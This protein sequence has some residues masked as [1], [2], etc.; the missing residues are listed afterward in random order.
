MIDLA[1]LPLEKLD[2]LIENHRAKKATDAPLYIQALAERARRKGNG[3]D[4]TTSLKA[5][6]KAAREQRFLGYKELADESGADWNKVYLSIGKHLDELAEYAHRKGWP[7]ISA[8]VVN[9]EN[10]ET[11]KLEPKSLKGF[12]TIARA[13]RHPV[14]DEIAFLS[15]EQKRVFA[16]A[17]QFDETGEVAQ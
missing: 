17:E 9:K 4:F 5:I 16:W 15:D 11:G 14:A 3:L 10:V 13:L 6:L 8:I 7:L 2:N 1:N 12:I